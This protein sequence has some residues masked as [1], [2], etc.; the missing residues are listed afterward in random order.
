MIRAWV[1]GIAI[2]TLSFSG[3]YMGVPDH[4][5]TSHCPY[6]PVSSAL[7]ATLVSHLEHW[8]VSTLGVIA[9][10]LLLVVALTLLHSFAVRYFLQYARNQQM[11]ARENIRPPLLVELFSRGLL[12]PRVP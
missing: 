4:A 3:M 8:Q 10:A 11:R 2:L 5:H 9:N 1:L 6:A 12:N 7:C